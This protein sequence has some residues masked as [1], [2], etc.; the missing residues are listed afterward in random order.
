M[1]KRG[2][3]SIFDCHFKKGHGFIYNTDMHLTI[4]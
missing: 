2:I 4:A 1:T 3:Y